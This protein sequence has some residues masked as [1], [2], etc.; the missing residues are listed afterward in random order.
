MITSLLA[1]ST[2]NQP[3]TQNKPPLAKPKGKQAPPSASGC[4]ETATLSKSRLKQKET[5]K[6]LWLKPLLIGGGLLSLGVAFLFLHPATR[7]KCIDFFSFIN[8]K[9]SPKITGEDVE[10]IKKPEFQINQVSESIIR[11]EIPWEDLPSR[12]S[13]EELAFQ[14]SLPQLLASNRQETIKRVAERVGMTILDVGNL[15]ERE[16]TIALI[17]LITHKEGTYVSDSY[18]MPRDAQRILFGHGMG[19]GNSGTP[20]VFEER[21]MPSLRGLSIQDYVNQHIPQGEQVWVVACKYG[22]GTISTETGAKRNI[23]WLEGE[24]VISAGVSA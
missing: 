11:E 10:S 21:N 13:P 12:L 18:E 4:Y 17:S 23:Y 5:D 20:W 9:E 6:K 3:L 2:T 7:E 8:K 19:G 24:W 1:I 22:Y 16:M 15:T 14:H